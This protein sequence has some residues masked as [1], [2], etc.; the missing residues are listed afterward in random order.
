LL[1]VASAAGN[2]FIIPRITFD[3]QLLDAWIYVSTL[4]IA[5]TRRVR[6]RQRSARRAR[7]THSAVRSVHPLRL[8]VILLVLGAWIA[9][10]CGGKISHE[11]GCTG[12]D[13]AN[14]GVAGASTANEGDAA[15]TRCAISC[16]ALAGAS[17]P[18]GY[19]APGCT[20]GCEQAIL[21]PCGGWFDL[22]VACL[23]EHGSAE[24]SPSGA[25]MFAD[26]TGVC[27]AAIGSYADC[28]AAG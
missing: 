21:G 17:C 6:A 16:A 25:P 19:D 2:S 1:G 24:C 9:G 8:F 12:S 23:L 22:A 13:C 4:I 15:G 7:T 18:A 11:T 14:G 28:A 10:G 5:T 26:P 27:A 3:E 20:A